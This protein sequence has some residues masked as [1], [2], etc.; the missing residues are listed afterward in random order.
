MYLLDINVISEL[1]KAK[2][3]KC[4]PKVKKWAG[5]VASSALFISVIAVLELEMGVMSLERRDSKQGT[6]LRQWLDGY[7]MPAFS[8][9]II[10]LDAA[11]AKRCAALHIPNPRSDRDAIIAA[12]ALVHGLSVVTR[13][14]RD[15]KGTGATVIDPWE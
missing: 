12:T 5:G 9:R 1:R 14:V 7:V 15:F 8:D 13:N 3:G 2:G 6:I 10:P 11:I 4:N